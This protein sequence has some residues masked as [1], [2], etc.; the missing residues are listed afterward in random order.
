MRRLNSMRGNQDGKMPVCGMG[1]CNNC[2]NKQQIKKQTGA[3]E[4]S[5]N[6]GNLLQMYYETLLQGYLATMRADNSGTGGLH[7]T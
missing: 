2:K 7:C 4:E 3:A 1:D 5:D 6:G